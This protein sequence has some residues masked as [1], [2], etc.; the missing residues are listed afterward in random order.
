MFGYGTLIL[1]SGRTEE[2]L[3]YVP[4]LDEFITALRGR[5]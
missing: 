4:R 5:P 1:D 2:T 3:D